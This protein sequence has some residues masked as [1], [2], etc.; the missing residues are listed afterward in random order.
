MTKRSYT[1]SYT[2]FFLIG[3][4]IEDNAA[5][6]ARMAEEGHQIGNHTWSHQRLD[7]ILPDEAAQEVA[8]TEAALEALLGGGEVPMEFVSGKLNVSSSAV[9]LLETLPHTLRNPVLKTAIQLF[10]GNIH[11]D[12]C[13]KLLHAA[14]VLIK[15]RL[16][17]GSSYPLPAG[18][19]PSDSAGGMDAGLL[20]FYDDSGVEDG[21][22]DQA[23]GKSTQEEIYSAPS[24]GRRGEEAA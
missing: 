5:L 13:V 20:W 17:P 19:I 9:K 23:A 3:Q 10:M 21:D 8:R 4:Q 24:G 16:T 1:C 18:R 7:G 2:T 14:S 11:D 6:V 15:Y 12:V 22:S